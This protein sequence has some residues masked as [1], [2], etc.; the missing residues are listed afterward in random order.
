MKM[1]IILSIVLGII[2]IAV[3]ILCVPFLFNNGNLITVGSS[4]LPLILI[5][6][7]IVK[8]IKENKNDS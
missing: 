5:T 6:A 2:Y 8:I 7:Y 1:S 4:A 3:V